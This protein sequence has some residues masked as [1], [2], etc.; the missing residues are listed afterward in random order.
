[1]CIGTLYGFFCPESLGD[2]PHPEC[3]SSPQNLPN[4]VTQARSYGTLWQETSFICC[5][6]HP[7]ICEECPFLVTF[8]KRIET[9]ECPPCEERKKRE[10]EEGGQV[11]SGG[12]A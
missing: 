5:G 2:N 10:A 9:L 11:G 1:M 3:P 6:D 7:S 8:T 4:G 12:A